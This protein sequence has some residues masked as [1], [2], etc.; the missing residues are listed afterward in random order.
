MKLCEQEVDM[1]KNV[2]QGKKIRGNKDNNKLYTKITTKVRNIR[3]WVK[4]RYIIYII[5]ILTQQTL[6][7]K[8]LL[9]YDFH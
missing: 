3:K 6:H 9:R 7:T 1:W 5:L 2:E 4:G 8:D